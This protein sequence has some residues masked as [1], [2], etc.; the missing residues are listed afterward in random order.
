M[1]EWLLVLAVV[2]LLAVAGALW[3]ADWRTLMWGGVWLLAAGWA[4]GLPV[5]VAF[6]V[7]LRRAL[8]H[9]GPVP[10]GWIWRPVALERELAPAE[11]R[12][13]SP[14]M[15]VAGAGFVLIVLG[16][17]LLITGMAAALAT[18]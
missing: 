9:R 16:L 3:L 11:R 14:L 8:G 17:A 2:A 12:R 13:T 5:G 15:Y 6:H 10:R 1:R 4:V 7:A 18:V